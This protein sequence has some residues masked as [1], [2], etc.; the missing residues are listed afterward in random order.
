MELQL[1]LEGIVSNNQQNLVHPP[2]PSSHAFSTIQTLFLTGI[3]G[4]KVPFM[5]PTQG[6]NRNQYRRWTCRIFILLYHERTI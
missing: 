5:S 3:S 1:K 4:V 2:P 6:Q